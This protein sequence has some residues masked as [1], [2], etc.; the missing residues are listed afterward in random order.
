MRVFSK[1]IV[2]PAT[3]GLMLWAAGLMLWAAVGQAQNTGAAVQTGPDG[4]N[5][6]TPGGATVQSGPGGA[7]VTIPPGAGQRLRDQIQANA[8]QRQELRN[9]RMDQR[10]QRVEQRQDE[11]NQLATDRT[12][13]WRFRFHNNHWWYWM[14]N[15]SWSFYHGTQWF[16]YDAKTY[17]NYYPLTPANPNVAADNATR[18]G[19]LGARRGPV[20]YQAAYRGTAPAT[21]Q[22]AFSNRPAAPDTTNQMTAPAATNSAPDT[23]SPLTNPRSVPPLGDSK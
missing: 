6:V 14:P 3:M 4:V 10:D 17:S 5:I 12:N 20:R 1:M 18:R 13:D 16:P 8:P 15:N 21:D 22:R 7:N 19:W 2:A 9:E 23:S 11:R